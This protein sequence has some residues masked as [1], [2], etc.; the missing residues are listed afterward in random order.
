MTK[1]DIYT[2]H[3][4]LFVHVI[5]ESPLVPLKKTII[6]QMVHTSEST[7]LKKKI[8]FVSSLASYVL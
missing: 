3:L 7:I 5:I 2:D 4:P 8:Y 6:T 1:H